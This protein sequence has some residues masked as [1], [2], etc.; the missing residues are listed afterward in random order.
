MWAWQSS[1]LGGRLSILHCESESENNVRA[2]YLQIVYVVLFPEYF[3]TNCGG[4]QGLKA[5]TE[6]ACTG[7]PP[8]SLFTKFSTSSRIRIAAGSRI[9]YRGKARVPYKH[10][11][12]VQIHVLLQTGFQLST[13]A[14]TI[15][16]VML[17]LIIFSVI[18]ALLMMFIMYWRIF[19]LAQL[20]VDQ[21]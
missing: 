12:Y 20:I 14:G 1:H 6:L 8:S 17:L 16:L 18:C 10:E 5:D 11:Y 13:Y 19:A 2:I 3:G 9:L 4:K 21:V 7:M 15:T